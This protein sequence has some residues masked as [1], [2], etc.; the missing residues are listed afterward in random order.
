VS[1]HVHERVDPATILAHAAR[2]LKGKDAAQQWR[3]PDLFDAPFENLPLRQALDFYRHEKQVQRRQAIAATTEAAV[4]PSFGPD[5]D[6]PRRDSV[7]Y[8]RTRSFPAPIEADR[9]PHLQPCRAGVRS[10]LKRGF[11][12][13]PF[14]RR[15]HSP[16]SRPI[17]VCA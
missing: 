8:R 7:Y 6:N 3:Q 13:S 17:L 15:P 9:T 1:L 12:Q 10:R 2:R 14:I 16:T 11:V 4:I 5:I